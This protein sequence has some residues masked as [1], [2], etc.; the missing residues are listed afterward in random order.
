MIHSFSGKNSDMR[1]PVNDEPPTGME[2][3]IC[4]EEVMAGADDEVF[5]GA[6][7][8][9]PTGVEDD[10]EEEVTT[11]DDDDNLYTSMGKSDG[12]FLETTS[13]SGFYTERPFLH[14]TAT[15]EKIL[16]NKD[17]FKIGRSV[18]RAD[19][20]ITNNNSVSNIHA[21]IFTNNGSDYYLKDNRSTNGTVVDGKKVDSNGMAVKLRNGSR[22]C[23]FNE[24]LEFR[25]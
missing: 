6:D 1:A 5:T 4:F 9:P 23:L 22:I 13:E 11:L 16:I 12:T 17:E 8:E 24:E 10:E 21:T 7:D 18:Q 19:Y 14:R 20:C 15:G 25:F 2:D 3:E